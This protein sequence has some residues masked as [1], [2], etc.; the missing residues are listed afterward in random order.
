[1]R[2]GDNPIRAGVVEA[3]SDHSTEIQ[4]G[5][6][7]MQPMVVFD[8]AAVAQ[9]AV[10]AGQPGDGA[11]DHGSVLAVFGQPLWVASGLSRG[12]LPRIMDPDPQ[13]SAGAAAGAASTQW[14]AGAGR[15]KGD[16]PGAGDL[17][18]QP[19]GAGRG[20]ASL[21]RASTS[22]SRASASFQAI[23]GLPG[24]S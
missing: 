16:S 21:T 5:G 9:P 19:V 8:D 11:F 10:A 1:M 20:A 12:A 7:V 17:S 24:S 2:L 18:G 15:A 14:T 3:Q 6:A 23:A 13:S 4:R 22:C